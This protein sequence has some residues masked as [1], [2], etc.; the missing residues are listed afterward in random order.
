MNASRN[1]ET[2]P[3]ESG[4]SNPRLIL[5]KFTHTIVWSFFVAC[6]VA[7]PLAG[8][9]GRFDWALA[10]SI[11]VALECVVIVTNQGRCPLTDV[12]ARYTD[13]RADNFDIYLPLW[14]A[15]HNKTIF[16]T[17]FV[18]GEVYVLAC[19]LTR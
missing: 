8:K 4:E 9:A 6:I 2:R 5:I 14:L 15:R 19:W 17:L 3:Q 7:I 11:L 12:A 16:G 18:A 10:L 13:N 1:S